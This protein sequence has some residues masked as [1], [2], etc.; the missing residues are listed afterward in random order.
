MSLQ[1]EK[2][3]NDRKRERELKAV[4]N[5]N[6]LDSLATRVTPENSSPPFL[7]PRGST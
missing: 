2:E 1:R 4:K 7:V 3:R 5:G 6:K